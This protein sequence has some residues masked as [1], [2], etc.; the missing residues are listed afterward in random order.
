[1]LRP[2]RPL[3]IYAQIANFYRD[4][5]LN[6]ELQPG[7]RLPAVSEIAESW[8]VASGTA[9][10]AIGQLQVEGAVYTSTQGSFVADG[11]V[12]PRTPS[13]RVRAAKRVKTNGDTVEV[14]AA[15]IVKPPNYVAELLGVPIGEQVVRREEI[16]WH[17]GRVTRFAVDWLSG[18]GM[19]IA[20][21]ELVQQVPVPG[22]IIA[23][24]ERAKRRKVTHGRDYLRGRASDDREA[25][26]LRTPIG[27]PVLAGTHVLGD[28]DGVILYG[29]W[30]L[31]PDLTVSYEWEAIA[32]DGDP[33]QVATEL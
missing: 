17:R 25:T 11:D 4:L 23:F 29:E 22:G 9:A 1:M 15:G 33:S 12:I 27:G 3:P 30:V 7:A 18:A 10:K 28:A 16:T 5:I 19:E 13:E 31:P 14:T 24:A 20:A 2:D 32:E 26:A 21:P 8:G 6:G